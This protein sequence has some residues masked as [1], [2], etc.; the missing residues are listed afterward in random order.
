MKSL[1]DFK[2]KYIKN[3][4]ILN[5]TQIPTKVPLEE[6][7]KFLIHEK[8]Q[9]LQCDILFLPHD[10]YGT[11]N[12]KKISIKKPTNFKSLSQSKQDKYFEDVKNANDLYQAEMKASAFKYALV[13]VDMATNNLDAEPMKDKSQLTC[14]SALNNIFKRKYIKLPYNQMITDAGSEFKGHF[15]QFLMKNKIFHTTTRL[16]RHQQLLIVDNKIGILSKYFN[17]AMSSIELDTKTTNRSW[18]HLLKQ[19]VDVFNTKEFVKPEQPIPPNENAWG[20]TKQVKGKTPQETLEVGA[21]VRVILD[22]PIDFVEG[23]NL[24]NGFRK[25]DMRFSK[26]IYTIKQILLNPS[27]PTLYKIDGINDAYYTRKHLQIV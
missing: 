25:G 9:I 23:K 20:N 17:L 10:T 12:I 7:P 1:A 5:L 21:T 15:E 22:H 27:Q 3:K 18:V 11:S 8:H 16:K 26:D 6:Q 24:H 13:V 14:I 4:E 19:L 2:E